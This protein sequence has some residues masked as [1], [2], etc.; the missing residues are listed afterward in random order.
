M[1][2]MRDSQ[3]SKVMRNHFWLVDKRR[4]WGMWEGLNE[5]K[6]EWTLDYKWCLSIS[7]YNL[8][9]SCKLII[10]HEIRSLSIK[11]ELTRSTITLCVTMVVVV[12]G[13]AGRPRL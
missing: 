3:S 9:Q 11:C 8:N 5:L 10:S 1:N 4:N 12:A 6:I 2:L 13:C 7:Y